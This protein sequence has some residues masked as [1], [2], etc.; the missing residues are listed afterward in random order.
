MR[1]AQDALCESFVVSGQEVRARES[2]CP[3]R[4]RTAQ[5]CAL[6]GK[7]QSVRDDGG[8]VVRGEDAA[9]G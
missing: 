1:T 7:T 6:R 8:R 4:G 2:E 9:A 3:R 5:L